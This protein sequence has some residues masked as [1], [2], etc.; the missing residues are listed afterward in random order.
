MYKNQLKAIKLLTYAWLTYLLVE[1]TIPDFHP[2][3]FIKDMLIQF[4]LKNKN[5]YQN[6]DGKLW[7]QINCIVFLFFEIIAIF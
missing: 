1:S 5:Q 3:V 6:L 7:V 4:K 2:F